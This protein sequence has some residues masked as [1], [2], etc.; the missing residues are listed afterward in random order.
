MI[1]IGILVK[2]KMINK[3]KTSIFLKNIFEEKWNDTFII[4]SLNDE[5]FTYGEFFGTIIK[6]KK[7]LEN[8]HLSK[9]D[10]LCLIMDNSIDLAALYFS[11]LLLGTKV[12]PI[13]PY[14]GNNEITEILNQ[15]KNKQIIYDEKIIQNLSL[16]TKLNEFKQNNDEIATFSNLA[17]FDTIN[18]DDVFLITFT[19][20]TTGKQKGVMH[21]FNNLF[22]SALLFQ[23][24]LNF[25]RNN[26]FLH[27]LPMTYMAGILN[28]LILPLI[29]RSKIVINRRTNITNVNSFWDIPIKYS[30]NTFWLIPTVLELLLKLDRGV[31]GIDFTR[32]NKITICVATSPLNVL[33]KDSFEKKY[34]VELFESYG[35]S[36]T[37]FISTNFFAYNKKS[38]VG[39]LLDNVEIKIL[40]DKEITVKT[41]WM[42]KGY[43]NLNSK[44]FFNNEFYLTGDLGEIDEDGFLFI[45][46]RKKDIIIKGGINISP[47][48]IEEIISE[49]QLFEEFTIM[50]FPD[51]L[52]GE[53]IVC[54]GIL[55]RTLTELNK[56]EINQKIIE[57]L[58]ISHL[59]DEFV[60]IDEL[61]K[62]LN[63]KIDK[64]KIRE[65][66]GQ[67]IK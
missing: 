23:K 53:K 1:L 10:F 30:V 11:S 37:L 22:Q 47:K 24:K 8:M 64:Y 6:F 16:G 45:V 59:I 26:V 49:I 14:K 41:P 66:Y 21:S 62:N 43:S 60:F 17:I 63:G 13:D 42:F 25:D 34:S 55:N 7:K 28:L 33:T 48:S 32:K 9:A 15:L 18:F 40:N 31:E 3:N 29:C 5:K 58:G 20:G 52:L 50:G 67:I 36:E 57:N 12:V 46:G 65:K 44:E 4:D 2:N 27:N 19:S 39:R 35:L 38:S 61:P 56:K 54:L 51:Q